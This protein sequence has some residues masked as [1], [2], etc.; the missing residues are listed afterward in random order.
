MALQV[1]RALASVI[2]VAIAIAG[3][4]EPA[5]IP[6]R[7]TVSDRT[8][9]PHDRLFYFNKSLYPGE[10]T[11]INFSGGCSLCTGELF[12]HFHIP[13]TGGTAFHFLFD[14]TNCGHKP[15]G[16]KGVYNLVS[17]M[18]SHRDH[19][20][21]FS[22]EFSSFANLSNSLKNIDNPAKILILL[23]TPMS[24]ALSAIGHMARKRIKGCRGIKQAMSPGCKYY[25]LD[26]MQTAYLGDGD[27]SR[28]LQVLKKIFWI[29]IT[30]HYDAS[31][32]LLS[33]QLGQFDPMK[34]NCNGTLI[35]P[36]N[37]GINLKN[38]L[39]DITNVAKLTN[40]DVA[41]Y[42]SAYELFLK[43]IHYAETDLGY[44]ILCEH[45]DGLD[46]IELRDFLVG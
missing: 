22:Q 23:R 45:R 11:E 14:K 44:P 18:D 35:K 30:E 33:Y 29:G 38:T 13:K 34:C 37:R 2:L 1:G 26:N 12:I 40:L 15:H 3:P 43:R 42:H 17:H 31:A 32:C 7:V 28:A 36:G 5:D 24:N 25:K 9:L 20:G 21:F 8:A 4:P 46:A 27:L 39:S 6:Q 41:L 19:C 16:V 10:R